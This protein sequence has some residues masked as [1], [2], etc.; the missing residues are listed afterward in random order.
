MPLEA[1]A[2]M[3]YSAQADTRSRVTKPLFRIVRLVRFVSTERTVTAT[4]ST[5]FVGWLVILAIACGDDAASLPD[6]GE[7]DSGTPDASIALP[8]T[9]TTAEECFAG[10]APASAG[11]DQ[12]VQIHQFVSDDGAYRVSRARERDGRW[13]G[14]ATI[15]FRLA[16]FWI[17][18]GAEDGTCV[19]DATAMTYATSH[20]N[21]DDRYTAST[22]R[23]AFAIHE[24]FDIL[25][26]RW[27]ITLEVREPNG[28]VAAG[29]LPLSEIGCEVIPADYEPPY[30]SCPLPAPPLEVDPGPDDWA[31]CPLADDFAPPTAESGELLV[32][33][34]ATYCTSFS[35]TQSL[36]EALAT[37][38]VI[39]FVEGTFDLPWAPTADYRVPVCVRAHGASGPMRTLPAQV[40][41]SVEVIDYVDVHHYAVSAPIDGFPEGATLLA[42]LDVESDND[43][44]PA[45]VFQGHPTQEFSV[46]GAG[47]HRHVFRLCRGTGTC[48]GS[49]P[50]D[51]C[52]F[53]GHELNHH[54][55]AFANGDVL[56]LRLMLSLRSNERGAFDAA[57]GRWKGRDFQQRD[58]LRLVYVP[59]SDHRTRSFAVLFDEPIDG[60]CGL[61][62]SD[63][64]P[65]DPTAGSAAT[66]D[67]ELDDIASVP[68]VAHALN[69]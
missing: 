47:T 15:Q 8:S 54:T 57:W 5:R 31:G 28:D 16:R 14:G 46:D 64:D 9:G 38:A 63:L 2:C 27:S 66:V 20:H 43:A 6:S 58:P 10:I 60:A 17:D 29:P 37:R 1:A 52:V 55:V 24:Y 42:E 3:A 35:A 34:D 33:A 69:Q 56:E 53:A 59:S 19:T 49:L 68:I 48:D 11:L 41:H 26:L 22:A 25:T 30:V 7:R 32:A 21:W 50:L 45:T 61:R 23:A 40:D 65:D 18:G 12:F 62:V 44:R 4:R 67:C 39:R 51:G 36:Q 13:I